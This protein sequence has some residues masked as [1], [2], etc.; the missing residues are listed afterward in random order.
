MFLVL[1]FLLVLCGD[2]RGR[3]WILGERILLRGFL[4]GSGGNLC[5]QPSFPGQEPY[6]MTFLSLFLDVGDA[7]YGRPRPAPARVAGTG[8]G[9]G[10]LP[11][12]D[13][14]PPPAG[15]AGGRGGR[16][17]RRSI[18]GPR[19]RLFVRRRGGGGGGGGGTS[20]PRGTGRCCP[21]HAMR[22]C[23]GPRTR[24]RSI[25]ATEGSN[26]TGPFASFSHLSGLADF[27]PFSSISVPFSSNVKQSYNETKN[28]AL[29]K[30]GVPLNQTPV[31]LSLGVDVSM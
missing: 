12:G 22:L 20:G 16:T 4:F 30:L 10:G 25:A 7:C 13:R 11:G 18:L 17:V 29:R 6:K 21:T 5:S 23:R 15:V 27:C 2:L 1:V 14:R 28:N 9:G 8:G 24:E 3:N 26:L 31:K 19:P